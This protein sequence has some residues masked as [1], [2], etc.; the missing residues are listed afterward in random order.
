MIAAT[1]RP[2]IL[3]PALMR[4]GRFDRQIVV[5]YP[6]VKGREEILKVH[7]R[8][9]PLAP[10]VELSDC[11][12]QIYRRLHR[13]RPEKSAERGGSAGRPRNLH[14]ITMPEIEEAT[15]K[16]VMGTEKRSHV[17]NDKEK[18][19]TAYHEAGHAV[20]TYYCPHR[21]RCIRFPSFPAGW[22]A[23]IP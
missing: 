2:D 14:A 10:D 6:D 20:V 21:I 13:R 12:C 19:P 3:D 18:K 1:N 17:I 9:K 4:P 8:G 16:V 7:A 11:H 23:V 15:I 22:R 5:N